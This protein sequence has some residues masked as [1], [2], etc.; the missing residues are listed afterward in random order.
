RISAVGMRLAVPGDEESTMRSTRTFWAALL[1]L[2]LLAQT[3]AAQAKGKEVTIKSGDEQIK[4][5]LAEPE[6]KGPHPAV[7][8]IQEWW[9]LNDWIKDNA[10][11]LAAKGFAAPAPDLDRG[12]AATEAKT[13]GQL[14]KGLPQDRALRD[15]K[16]A[17]DLLATLPNVDKDRIGSLGWCMGGGYSLQLALKE[18]RVKA[19][20]ICYGRVV[21]DPAE[22]KSLNASVLGIFGENDKGIPAKGVREFEKAL[23]EAG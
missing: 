5:F 19:C 21:T 14:M 3:A 10:R 1:A 12:K 7:V 6:G 2:P 4:G 15:L 11:R 16:G 23:K 13:A 18:P 8:V 17:V 22:L 9:G 20:V